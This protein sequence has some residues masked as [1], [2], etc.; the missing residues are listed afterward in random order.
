MIAGKIIPAIATT[1]AM[2][3][4]AVSAEIYKFV[5]GYTKIEELKNSFINLALP[6]WV[7]SEPTE[8]GKIKSKDYDPISMCQVK[9]IPEGYTI[10]DKTTVDKGSLTLQQLIDHLQ[11]S[12]GIEVTLVSAGRFSL[13]N[14]YL[15]GNK[16][17]PRLLAKIE[18]TY[19]KI[20]EETIPE[21]RNWIHLELGGSVKGED[22][23]DFQVP[24]VKYVFRP[25][26]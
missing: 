9:A 25:M 20:S 17:A 11:E 6:L 14:S 1:T 5:Q 4:G 16:H 21:G 10:Y 3:T 24:P 7:F 15:P 19:E 22:D 8:V 26:V 12:V 13:Y 2:I 18:D 23:C